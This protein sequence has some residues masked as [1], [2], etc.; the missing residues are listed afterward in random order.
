MQVLHSSIKLI[1]VDFT[2]PYHQD[3]TDNEE[4]SDNNY[5]LISNI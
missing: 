3:V 1:L 5:N 2:I 4:D